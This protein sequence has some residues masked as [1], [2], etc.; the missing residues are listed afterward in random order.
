MH[1]PVRFLSPHAL[2]R[3]Q[4]VHRRHFVSVIDLC[5]KIANAPVCLVDTDTLAD[6]D[7]WPVRQLAK[8]T[9]TLFGCTVLVQKDRCRSSCQTLEEFLFGYGWVT[10]QRARKRPVAKEDGA[11]CS[12]PLMSSFAQPAQ[13]RFPIR[14]RE[15]VA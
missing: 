11:A 7:H 3:Q 6:F 13:Q 5:Q 15:R 9:R 1:W 10:S 8:A 4:H 2:R 12:L 14:H